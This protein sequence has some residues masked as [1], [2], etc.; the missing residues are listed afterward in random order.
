MGE[1]IAVDVEADGLLGCAKVLNQERDPHQSEQNETHNTHDS[2]PETHVHGW[3][4]R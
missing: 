2:R 4:S 3:A 1:F